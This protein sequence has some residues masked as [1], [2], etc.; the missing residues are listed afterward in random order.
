MIS[1]ETQRERYD[2]AVPQ[3]VVVYLHLVF[4]AV[5]CAAEHYFGINGELVVGNPLAAVCSPVA[6][7]GLFANDLLVGFAILGHGETLGGVGGACRVR[8]AI[9]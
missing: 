2:R 4:G 6:D 9:R 1:A 8:R 3:M 7:V 5:R